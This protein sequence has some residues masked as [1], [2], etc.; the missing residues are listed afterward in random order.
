MWERRIAD[1]RRMMVPAGVIIGAVVVLPW[2]VLVYQQHGW[3]HIESFVVGENLLRFVQTVGGAGRGPLFYVP[4]MLGFIFPWSLFL[5]FALWPVRRQSLPGRRLGANELAESARRDR[6]GRTEAGS[7][8][9]VKVLVLW[10]VV[11]VLFFSLSSTKQDLCILPIIPA[12][13][14]LVGGLL[15]RGLDSPCPENR[16]LRW[17]MVA[18]GLVLLV[19]G[20]SLLG[21]FVAPG[22]YPLGGVATS[23]VVTVLAGLSAV[24]LAVKKR[25]FAAVTVLSLSLAVV[26]WCFVVV[27]LP[28]FERYKPVRPLVRAIESRASTAAV[29]GYY[30]AA[31][32]SMV[33]Y[34]RRPV[35][36]LVDPRQLSEAFSSGMSQ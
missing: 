25:L 33:F 18:T 22:R 14:A 23:S 6:E 34:M 12:A 27:T 13:A 9:T 29:I 32:P 11:F 20:A 16:R 35:L 10:V 30:K 8:R 5:P 15:A 21:L 2:Y 26:S 3:V 7:Q 31:F 19:V 24:A 17:I 1:V 36:E 4:V 28:D